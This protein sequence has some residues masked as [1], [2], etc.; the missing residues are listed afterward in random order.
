MNNPPFLD[1]PRNPFE[2][3]KPSDFNKLN[4]KEVTEDFVAENFKLLGW[5]VY[6][7]FTDSGIDRIIVKFICP[8]DHTPLDQN[9]SNKRCN[10][11]GKVPIEITRFI[12]VKTRRLVNNIFGFTLKSKDIRIDPRHVYL[13]YSDNTMDNKQD[14]LII[15]V[16]EL[17]AFFSKNNINPFSSKSFRTGN[18]KLNS[19]KYNPN[20]DTWRWGSI[21]WECFRNL[22]GL[23]LLQ[24]PNVDLN[25]SQEIKDTRDLANKLQNAFSGGPSY[26]QHAEIVVN[27]E[28]SAKVLK[29]KNKNN[30]LKTRANVD[31]YLTKNC[32]LETLESSQKY[33]ENVKLED[34][35]GDGEDE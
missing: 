27:N 5:D 10:I 24:N 32:S 29:Y 20:E 8:S 4:K 7:P 12:Q 34:T 3:V 2:D 17:L 30:I 35:L 26:S 18:N 21:S 16:K 25:I 9:L 1:F 19:L 28:L 33:F 11:C 31:S 6:K 13:L 14:F 22:S 15:P 23:K